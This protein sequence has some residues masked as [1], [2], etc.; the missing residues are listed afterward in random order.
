MAAGGEEE[1]KAVE[2]RLERATGQE[3]ERL[4]IRERAERGRTLCFA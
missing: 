2:E 1:E 3:I 4:L